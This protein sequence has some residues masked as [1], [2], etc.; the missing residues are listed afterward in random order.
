[1]LLKTSLILLGPTYNSLAVG[2]HDY[3]G[4]VANVFKAFRRGRVRAQW[5]EGLYCFGGGNNVEGWRLW[6]LL[7]FIHTLT[8]HCKDSFIVQVE[9]LAIIGWTS[10]MV[11][12]SRQAHTSFTSLCYLWTRTQPLYVALHYLFLG[13]KGSI[14][15]FVE[16]LLGQIVWDLSV[17]YLGR[18]NLSCIMVELRWID[19]QLHE[20]L[21]PC[22][23]SWFLFKCSF[24]TH[25]VCLW[26]FVPRGESVTARCRLHLHQWLN[27]QFLVSWM[28]LYALLSF[29]ALF[30]IFLLSLFIMF[31][32]RWL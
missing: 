17:N 31:N 12:L 20:L 32:C 21:W 11:L 28:I 16:E 23:V 27:L 22:L 10:A 7:P 26:A 5:S 30:T 4:V 1:M 13:L 29:W 14:F 15:I 6:V 19:C 18:T 24:I 25:Q 3:R 9:R 8:H 2:D